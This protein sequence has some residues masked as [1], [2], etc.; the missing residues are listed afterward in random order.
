MDISSRGQQKKIDIISTPLRE[1]CYAFFLSP[2]IEGFSFQVQLAGLK[3]FQL[4]EPGTGQICPARIELLVG[5]KYRTAIIGPSLLQNL[6][7][8][9]Y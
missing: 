1:A 3:I 8:S 2:I 5:R 6:R 7:G 4:A 9:G